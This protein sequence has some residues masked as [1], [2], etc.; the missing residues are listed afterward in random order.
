[1]QFSGLCNLVALGQARLSISKGEFLGP[2]LLRE[3]TENPFRAPV[4]CPPD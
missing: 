4:L 2:R 1:M 3:D